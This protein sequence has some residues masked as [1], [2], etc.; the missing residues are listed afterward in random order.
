MIIEC[1]DLNA[2]NMNIF[3]HIYIYI[4]YFHVYSS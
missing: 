1:K 3:E 4:F 2:K